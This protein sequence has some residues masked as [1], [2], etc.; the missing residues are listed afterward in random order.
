MG[1][2]DIFLPCSTCLICI[3]TS[4]WLQALEEERSDRLGKQQMKR[5]EIRF[6]MLQWIITR[7][8]RLIC[9]LWSESSNERM[10]VEEQ[11]VCCRFCCPT[12][13]LL[14]LYIISQQ[15]ELHSFRYICK[16]AVTCC[17]GFIYIF[18]VAAAPAGWLST[19]VIWACRRYHCITYVSLWLAATCIYS[20]HLR[21]WRSSGLNGNVMEVTTSLQFFVT[22][23][24]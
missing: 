17:R 8:Y 12:T 4:P 11:Y 5:L 13:T 1:N 22:K 21:R 24:Q 2:L 10:I 16:E 14:L 15:S 23:G 19:V 6:Q 7:H 20:Q 3:I 18:L 9:D